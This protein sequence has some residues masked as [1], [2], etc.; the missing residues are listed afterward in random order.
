MSNTQSLQVEISKPGEATLDDAAPPPVAEELEVRES[1]LIE[2]PS[3]EPSKPLLVAVVG[4][5]AEV[6]ESVAPLDAPAEPRPPGGGSE[7]RQFIAMLRRERKARVRNRRLKRLGW[8]VSAAAAA[9]YLAARSSGP[10]AQAGSPGTP[11][12]LAAEAELLPREEPRLPDLPA[13]PPEDDLRPVA[14]ATGST[15]DAA[16]CE[17]NFAQQRWRTAVESCTRVF[18]QAPGAALA[19]RIAHAHY[20]RGQ[21]TPAGFWARTALGLGT[22]DADAYVLIGHS[23][24][25]AGHTRNAVDA[26]R[27]YLQSSPRGWHAKR[28]RAALLELE[29]KPAYRRPSARRS[30]DRTL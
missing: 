27:R 14:E 19:L 13:A 16:Q 3:D 29:P 28:L 2:A 15:S 7:V 22:R 11:L 12:A 5:A 4:A 21:S 30:V 10:D 6:T 9:G 1:A 23:E 8:A 20:A 18:E 24:R 26:Y 25:Q 17:E